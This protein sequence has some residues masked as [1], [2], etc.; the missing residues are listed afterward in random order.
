LEIFVPFV[1]REVSAADIASL[2]DAIGRA[3]FR[4]GYD[5]SEV[6]D[7]EEIS[8]ATGIEPQRVRELL[9]DGVEPQQPPSGSEAREDYYRR[10]V[11]QRLDLLRRRRRKATAPTKETYRQIAEEVDLSH[12]LISHLLSGKRSARVDYSSPLETRYGV[13]HGF[14]SKPEGLALADRLKAIKDGLLAGVLH[15]SIYTLGG[16][17]MAMRQSGEAPPSLEDLVEAMDALIART[18]IQER[19]RTEAP[20]EPDSY[21]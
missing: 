19:K 12:T 6:L 4:L 9:V 10:L 5:T 13:P 21:K 17:Q 1:P 11:G 7:I 20:G 16:K 3:A 2:V 15:E 14:L 18:R 8:E